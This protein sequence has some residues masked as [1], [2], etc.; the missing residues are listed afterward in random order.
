MTNSF[1]LI[2]HL[3]RFGKELFISVNQYIGLSL[4]SFLN[5]SLSSSFCSEQCL[6]CC[7]TSTSCDCLPLYNVS[8][9]VFLNCK[10]LWIKASAKWINVNF[11]CRIFQW[12]GTFIHSFNNP[13]KKNNNIYIHTNHSKNRER[14]TH[15]VHISE[16]QNK[17]NTIYIHFLI[18]THCYTG[19]KIYIIFINEC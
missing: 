18:I 5:L 2:W 17:K 13:K 6:K 7:M 9:I 1:F 11:N 15:S 19:N 4:L 8:L 10:S 14:W 16:V 3:S 12:T